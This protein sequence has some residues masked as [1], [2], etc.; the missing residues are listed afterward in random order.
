M[1]DRDWRNVAGFYWRKEF[2]Y[3]GMLVWA[4]V[5]TKLAENEQGAE[6]LFFQFTETELP[7]NHHKFEDSCIYDLKLGE[8]HLKITLFKTRSASGMVTN[9]GIRIRPETNKPQA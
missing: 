2:I 5:S 7:K 1:Q 6:C 3:N 4:E 8:R 9:C